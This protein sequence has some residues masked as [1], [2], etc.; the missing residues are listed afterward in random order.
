MDWLASIP[1]RVQPVRAARRR[2]PIDRRLK[3]NSHNPTLIFEIGKIIVP[4][5]TSEVVV[6]TDQLIQLFDHRV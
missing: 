4:G 1:V 2:N 5:A 6:T 3:L